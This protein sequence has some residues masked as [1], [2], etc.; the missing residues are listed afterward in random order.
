VPS[1]FVGSLSPKECL[2]LFA[3]NRVRRSIGKH[4]EHG[5]YVAATQHF[6]AFSD[7]RES[8]EGSKAHT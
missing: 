8:A 1:L 5:Q 6:A 7:G 4:H 2:K 3:P